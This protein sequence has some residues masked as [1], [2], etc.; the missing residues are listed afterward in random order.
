[1][2]VALRLLLIA[3]LIVLAYLA[4]SWKAAG[5]SDTGKYVLPSGSD[6]AQLSDLPPINSNSPVNLTAEERATINIFEKAA[7]S[8]V[9]I[10]T[11]R[12]K[13]DFWTMNVMEIP[14]GTGSGFVWDR[15]GHIV[16]NQHVVRGADRIQVT[17][18]DQ[19]TWFAEKIGEEPSKR[20]CST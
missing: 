12:V 6:S 11:S 20:P 17:L 18:A 13:R 3:A 4:G 16:T 14:Q 9:F 19:T 1:M 15:A 2:K 8:V 5:K 10:T 7:P